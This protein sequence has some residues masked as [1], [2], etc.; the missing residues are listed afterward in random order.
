MVGVVRAALVAAVFVIA[1]T[2]ASAQSTLQEAEAGLTAT[3]VVPG[4]FI[5]CTPGR[6]ADIKDMFNSQVD[7]LRNDRKYTK[8]RGC[9]ARFPTYRTTRV[10]TW[11]N[12]EV[13]FSDDADKV[14]GGWTVRAALNAQGRPVVVLQEYLSVVVPETTAAA[15]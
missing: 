5:V 7:R 14:T 4:K 3:P 11:P 2:T 9:V 10:P 13:V 15:K 6:H 12:I 1:T 8:A